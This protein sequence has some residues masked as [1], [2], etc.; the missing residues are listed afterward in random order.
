MGNDS[1]ERDDMD[2]WEH[3][4]NDVTGDV[5]SGAERGTSTSQLS[6]SSEFVGMTQ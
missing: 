5:S 2:D 1:S 4:T 6:G 3:V